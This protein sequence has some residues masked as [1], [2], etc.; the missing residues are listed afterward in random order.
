METEG[1]SNEGIIIDASWRAE[2]AAFWRYQVPVLHVRS[3]SRYRSTEQFEV[4]LYSHYRWRTHPVVY[5][6][7]E[8][9]SFSC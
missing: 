5:F 9:I 7:R 2:M 1:R 3:R 8:K 4:E 6:S